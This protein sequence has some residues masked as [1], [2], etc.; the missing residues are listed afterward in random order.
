M[1]FTHDLDDAL[2]QL[3]MS[4]KG[5]ALRFIK[6]NFVEDVHYKIVKPNTTGHGGQNKQL[7]MMT[8]EAFDLCKTTM[9]MRQRYVPHYKNVEQVRILM[10]I[11]NQTIG[12]ITTAYTGITDMIRQQRF[13][14]YLVDLYFPEYRLVIEC[15]ENGHS[16]R[17]PQQEHQREQYIKDC[18]CEIIRFN[19]NHRTFDMAVVICQINKVIMKRD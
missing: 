2:T 12:F 14:T 16:D 11:E 3:G 19:P 10:S 18:G 15:D 8:R 17:D 5:N 1:E 13:G 4:T 6:K 7:I 9:N